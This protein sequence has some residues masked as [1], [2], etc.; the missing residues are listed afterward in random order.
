MDKWLKKIRK[1]T[2]EQNWNIKKE[3]EIMKK[4]LNR[5][6]RAEKY[7]W[8]ESRGRGLTADKGIST[9]APHL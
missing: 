9:T 1:M 4:E 7:N 5:K 8:N 6:S 2:H 3:I